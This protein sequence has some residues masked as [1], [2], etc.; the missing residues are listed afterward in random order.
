MSLEQRLRSE[1]T[2]KNVKKEV[3]L[4]DE[5]EELDF[6]ELVD[7]QAKGE[8]YVFQSQAADWLQET[9]LRLRN[10]SRNSKTLF[11]RFYWKHSHLGQIFR[12]LRFV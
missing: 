3:S 12:N 10:I 7:R 9:K 1:V 11:R 6:E 4:S 5:Q 8:K 2:H